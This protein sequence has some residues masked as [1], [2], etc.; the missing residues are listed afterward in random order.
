M[1]GGAERSVAFTTAD[2]ETSLIVLSGSARVR[3]GNEEHDI[4]QFDGVYIPRDS[5]V[6][7]STRDSADIAEFSTA[8]SGTYPFEVVRGTDIASDPAL[9]FNGG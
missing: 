6:E 1:L 7:V 2:R 8:V 3:A 5:I 4:S 9:P